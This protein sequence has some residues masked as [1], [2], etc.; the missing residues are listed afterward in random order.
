M[1]P[2]VIKISLTSFIIIFLIHYIFTFLKNNLTTTKYKDLIVNNH[3][4][5]RKNTIN[6]NIN[7][8]ENTSVPD[9]NIPATKI[10]DNKNDNLIINNDNSTM[11]NELKEYLETLKKGNTP[12]TV[13]G[14]SDVG[15]TLEQE[16]LQFS[17]F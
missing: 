17:N 3:T 15:N 1:I 7:N 14:I 13:S 6:K 11:K 8:I 2:W 5:E 4:E 16:S 9:N 12:D 10:P